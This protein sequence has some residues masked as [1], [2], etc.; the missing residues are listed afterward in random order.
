MIFPAASTVSG[1][2]VSKC[3]SPLAVGLRLL[4]AMEAAEADGTV[5]SEALWRRLRVVQQHDAVALLDRMRVA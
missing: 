5:I 1:M 2:G 3:L 4:T